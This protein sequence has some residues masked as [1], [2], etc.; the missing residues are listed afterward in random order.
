MSFLFLLLYTA[1]SLLLVNSINSEKGTYSDKF[2]FRTTRKED[3]KEWFC[4]E[5]PEFKCES[6]R[7]VS[8]TQAM[9]SFM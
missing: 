6:L 7:K 1:Y 2:C 4:K 5:Y 3:P 8:N 9:Y